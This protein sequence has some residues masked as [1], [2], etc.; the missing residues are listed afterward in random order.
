MEY[1]R[2]TAEKGEI[3]ICAELWKELFDFIAWAMMIDMLSR[4]LLKRLLSQANPFF[5]VEGKI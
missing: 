2:Q 5:T 3:C 4:A 1:E